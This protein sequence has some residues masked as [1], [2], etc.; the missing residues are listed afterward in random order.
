MPIDFKLH[1]RVILKLTKEI[2][3]IVWYD[4]DYPE[5]DS[6]LIEIMGKNEMPHFYKRDDFE[7]LGE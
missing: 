5:H 1:D 6:F 2:G 7:V 4:E 3:F